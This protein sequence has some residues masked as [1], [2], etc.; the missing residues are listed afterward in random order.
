M[1]LAHPRPNRRPVEGANDMVSISPSCELCKSE[2]VP[3]RRNQRFCGRQCAN[4][5]NALKKF[6]RPR[7]KKCKVCRKEFRPIHH[8][9]VFCSK[10][11]SSK[12]SF[13]A[14]STSKESR[15]CR[16]CGKTFR[17]RTMHHMFCRTDC[18]RAN[19]KRNARV[20]GIKARYGLTKDELRRL[21]EAQNGLCAICGGPPVGKYN[22]LVVDHCHKRKTVRSLLCDSCNKGL[23]C[24]KDEPSRLRAAADYLEKHHGAEQD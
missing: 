11:C 4:R 7:F 22:A 3:T 24:F 20:N 5:W 9:G 18:Y 8:W 21:E 10:S 16:E 15:Q 1:V 17:P 12:D 14:R 19:F 2:F 6:P 23:G 13:E